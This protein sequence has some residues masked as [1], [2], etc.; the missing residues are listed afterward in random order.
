V[1]LEL[2]IV[3]DGST[4][5]CVE[6]VRD[7]GDPRLRIVHQANLGCSAARNTG[8]EAASHPWVALLDADDI[9]LD[10]HLEELGRI[11]TAFPGAGLIGTSEFLVEA[12]ARSAR[13]PQRPSNIRLIP[14]LAAIA[15]GEPTFNASSVAILKQAWDSVGRS[16]PG[17]AGPDRE[18]WARVSLCW[19]VAVSDRVT[20]VYLRA[21]GSDSDRQRRQRH[22]KAVTSLAELSSSVAMLLERYPAADASVRRDIDDYVLRY[23]DYRLCEAIAFWDP[24]ALRSLR[25]LYP[26]RRLE[27]RLLLALASLPG[28][29]AKRACRIGLLPRAAAQ[30]L[31]AWWPGESHEV[32][33]L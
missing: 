33:P 28:P 10:S 25:S 11:R 19:P 12:G 31:Q 20:T 14:Y 3:D 9:W 32:V 17:C 27:H 29:L 16:D 6:T 22:G 15:R 1:G 2:I 13:V 4:D 7:I 18:L 30:R 23:F 26:G 8:I 24:V 5:G 21:E